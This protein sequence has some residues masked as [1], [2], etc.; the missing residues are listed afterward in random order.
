VTIGGDTP[1]GSTV[2]DGGTQSIAITADGHDIWD[3]ADDFHYVYQEWSGDGEIY[4]RV[5]EWTTSP[6]NWSKAGVMFRDDL[7]EGSAF[8]DMIVTGNGQ[9]S[10]LGFQWRD[11]A[12]GG[13]GSTHDQA[14]AVAPPHWVRLVRTGN[15]FQGWRSVDGISWT[16]QGGNHTTTM[17]DPIYI[18]LCVTSHNAG[19]LV[20]ATIDNVGGDVQFGDWPYPSNPTPADGSTIDGFIYID[21]L[22]R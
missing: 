11:T 15:V 16:Q 2:Y 7:S 4:C 17:T 5:V 19:N 20:T 13:C 18:G 9:G 3:N 12:G 8:V 14:P 21:N 6:F 10:G 1:A 22:Q